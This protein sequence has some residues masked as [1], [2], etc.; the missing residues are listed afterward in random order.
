MT[1]ASPYRVPVLMYHE[2]ADATA[3]SSSLAVAPD[4]FTDQLAY[5][6]DAGFNTLTGENSPRFSPTASERFLSGPWC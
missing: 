3:T 1:A 6:H 2:I 5:L 4:V